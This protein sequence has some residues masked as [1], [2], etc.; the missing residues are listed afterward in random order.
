MSEPLAPRPRVGVARRIWLL[1]TDPRQAFVSL[2]GRS[3]WVAPLAVLVVLSVLLT[4]SVGHRVGWRAVIEKRLENNP[5]IAQMTP[6]Q[7]QQMLAQA[8]RSASVFSY[9]G[10]VLGPVLGVVVTAGALWA[11]FALGLGAPIRFPVA[12]SVVSYSF[13]PLALQALI[14][15]GVV[16][17]SP[18]ENVNL[19]NLVASNAGAFLAATSPA[20]FRALA[21]S[22]DLFSLWTLGLLIIG[23]PVA[24]GNAVSRGRSRAVVL[25]LWLLYV[26]AKSALAAIFS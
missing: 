11:V 6:E 14:A 5:R 22:F 20:W 10:A 7:R 23:F 18:P 25:S 24:T 21:A 19:E 9:A 17:L 13:L 3:E 26:A 15:I 1:L 4:A 12:V 8:E 16:W 2:E